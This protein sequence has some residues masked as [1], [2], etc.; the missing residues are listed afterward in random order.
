MDIAADAMAA[1]A[2]AWAFAEPG[3]GMLWWK[4]AYGGGIEACI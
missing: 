1:A 3:G 4:F 2:A